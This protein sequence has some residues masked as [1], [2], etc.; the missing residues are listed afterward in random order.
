MY[1]VVSTL[2]VGESERLDFW[3]DLICDVFVQ[4]DSAPLAGRSLDA[5]VATTTVGP[6]TVTKVTSQPLVVRRLPRHIARAREDDL[7]VS[8]QQTHSGLV[9]QD[10]REAVLRPG[11]LALYDSSRPYTLQFADWTEQLV[12]QVSRDTL[13]ERCRGLDGVAAERF[14]GQDGAGAV[15]SRFLTALAQ[16]LEALDGPTALRLADTAIDVMATTLGSAV[17]RAAAPESQA[18]FHLTRAKQCAVAHL[19]DPD[20]D[21]DAWAR[22]VGFSTRHLTRLFG[23]EGSTP[24]RWLRSVRLERVR[25]DLSDPALAHVSVGTIGCSWGFRDDAHLSRVFA[26]RFELP[27]GAYRRAVLNVGE[28]LGATA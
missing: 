2:E 23:S 4:L 11:D 5:T 13:A 18:A 3:R 1:R 17:G 24:A 28:P 12:F 10:G 22:A 26:R 16:Q 21:V 15:L 14:S 8:V 9:R 27:P 20:F 6:L 19:P 25:R 7:L